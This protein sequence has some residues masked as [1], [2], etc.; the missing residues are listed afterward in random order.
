MATGGV[1]TAGGLLG[2][3]AVHNIFYHNSPGLDFSYMEIFNYYRIF[4]R[5]KNRSE[6]GIY[7]SQENDFCAV[8]KP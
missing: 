8:E 1:L 5:H 4:A 2:V 3:T 6:V 7:L